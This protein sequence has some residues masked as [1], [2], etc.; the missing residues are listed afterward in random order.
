MTSKRN[1]IGTGAMAVAIGI[2]LFEVVY[3]LLMGYN[4]Q[5]YTLWMV[6]PVVGVPT[7][8]AFFLVVFSIP[9]L[10]EEPRDV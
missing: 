6:D 9:F 1:K 5:Q 2:I 8:V 3:Q 10:E 4:P 7:F